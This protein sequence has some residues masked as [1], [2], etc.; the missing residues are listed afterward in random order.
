MES[1]AAG[2]KT[3]LLGSFTKLPTTHGRSGGGVGKSY[4]SYLRSRKLSSTNMSATFLDR[5]SWH[6]TTTT[7]RRTTLT[8]GYFIYVLTT[9][10]Y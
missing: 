7:R 8:S 6:T 3:R 1:R 5:G 2:H 9:E 4:V 10:K